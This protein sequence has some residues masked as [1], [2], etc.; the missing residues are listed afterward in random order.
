MTNTH[1]T[2]FAKIERDIDAG[3]GIT[4]YLVDSKQP[5]PHLDTWIEQALLRAA[6]VSFW[7]MA[8]PDDA[9]AHAQSLPMGQIYQTDIVPR[10]TMVLS[11]DKIGD[12]GKPTMLRRFR[13]R[14]VEDALPGDV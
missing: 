13:I 5:K 6:N 7:I 3:D 2:E 1:A 14:F 4:T 8:H 12:D 9:K 11:I 10:G